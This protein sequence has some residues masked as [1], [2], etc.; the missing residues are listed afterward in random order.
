MFAVSKLPLATPTA[1]RTRRSRLGLAWMWGCLLLAGGFLING[2]AGTSRD[3]HALA[4]VHPNPAATTAPA[5][6]VTKPIRDIRVGERVLA[7]NPE[8]TDAERTLA[9]E[10]DPATWRHI[11]LEMPKPDGSLLHIDLL[12]PV[13]WLTTHN[14]SVDDKIHLDLEEMGAK[15]AAHVL[16]INTCPMIATGPGNIV[17]GTF[18]H[19]SGNVVDLHIAGVSEPIG[20]TSNHPF[21]SEDRQ[22]FV[23][24]EELQ[25]GETLRSAAGKL[26]YLVS[27]SARQS[28]HEVFNLEVECEHVYFVSPLGVLV[29]N[30]YLYQKVGPNGQHLKYGITNNPATRYTQAE[31]GGGR[32]KILANGNRQEMLRLERN[33]HSTMP[34][35][36]EEGQQIYLQIQAANGLTLP[37]Y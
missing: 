3:E 35:G 17:T 16:A 27:S 25:V 30:T 21:W 24:A 6:Y 29:H 14:A 5:K 23:P 36:P 11:E 33:L 4:A 31:L 28:E 9:V 19:S 13:E 7:R 2:L 20:T 34:I 12:R 8:V 18:K 22:E 32:L 37:P 1:Q 15:G 10:P 26:V